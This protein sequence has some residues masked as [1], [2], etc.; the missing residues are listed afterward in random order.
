M[1]ELNEK[2]KIGVRRFSFINWIG[3]YSLYKKETLRFLIVSGQTILGPVVTAILFLMVI[4]LAIGENRGVVLQVLKE[5]FL[6]N[7]HYFPS[8]FLIVL[9]MMNVQKIVGLFAY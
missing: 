3:F 7:P 4:S 5:D 1:V 9:R 8:F 6:P 2:Y